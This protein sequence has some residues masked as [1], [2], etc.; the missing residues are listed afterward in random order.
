MPQIKPSDY[1]TTATD[2][3]GIALRTT[4]T[5]WLAASGQ[6]RIELKQAY[7][8]LLA[9]LQRLMFRDLKQIDRDPQIKQAIDDLRDLTILIALLMR[10][11]FRC[12]VSISRLPSLPLPCSTVTAKSLLRSNLASSKAWFS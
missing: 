12:S 10:F 9:R 3:V 5:E 6:K 7:N 8:D 4:R 2:E 11:R 1:M